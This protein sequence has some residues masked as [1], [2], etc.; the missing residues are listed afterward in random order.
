MKYNIYF[1]LIILIISIVFL[2]TGCTNYSEIEKLKSQVEDLEE[3]LEEAKKDQKT[4]PEKTVEETLEEEY[5]KDENEE[6][7]E[8]TKKIKDRVIF[9]NV[10]IIESSISKFTTLCLKNDIEVFDEYD[11]A[12]CDSTVLMILPIGG[13]SEIQ[14]MNDYVRKGGIGV[15][16]YSGLSNVERELNNFFEVSINNEIISEDASLIL[17]GGI[18]AFFSDDLKVGIVSEDYYKIVEYIDNINGEI[19]WYSKIKSEQ[20]NKDRY[21]SLLKQIGKGC[22]LFSPLPY[23]RGEFYNHFSI[24]LGDKTIDY[25]DNEEYAKR[26]IDWALEIN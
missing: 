3:K 7:V 12:F 15:Y 5:L 2:F 16:Y 1:L 10:N 19:I 13:H 20:T 8:E 25:Y 9:F 14:A 24:F 6:T 23:Y 17:D 11:P 22:V 4:E 21:F 26:L 18:W